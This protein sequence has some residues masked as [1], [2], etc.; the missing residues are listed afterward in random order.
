M[1]RAMLL[2]E[3]CAHAI[4]WHWLRSA[5]APA[6]VYGE[7]TFSYCRPFRSG[8]EREA[9]E[10]AE[11]IA[12]IADAFD[13]PQLES[14]REVMRGV[15]DVRPALARASMG[16]LLDDAHLLELQRWFEA[17]ERLDTL[18]AGCTDLPRVANDALAA[19][20]Q[21]LECGRTQQGFYL[22]DGFDV[23]LADAR[24]QLAR[25][26]AAYEAARGRAVAAVTTAFG[27][28]ISLPEF[29]VMRT[30]MHGP[31]PVGVRVVREAPTYLLCEL[32][33]D[34]RALDALGARDAAAIE[35]AQ[36]EEAV[37]ARLAST[38][39]SHIGALSDAAHAFG[40]VD[41]L[42]GAARFTRAYGCKVPVISDET[43][44][45]FEGARFVPL[46]AELAAA[47][48]VFTP[49]DL[50]LNG[51]AVLTGPNMGGKS[52]ALRTCGFIAACCSFGL[53]VP[54]VRAQVS[55]FDEIVWLGIGSDDDEPGG[56]LSSFAREVVRLRDVLADD[57]QPRL[58]LLDEF[59]RT[60]TP[61]EGKALFIAVI[62]RLQAERACGLAATHLSGVAEAAHVRHYAVRGLRGIPKRP[63]TDDLALALKRWRHRWTIHWRR[64][65]ASVRAKPMRSLWPHCWVSMKA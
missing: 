12:R 31:L 6:G 58:V 27:R 1:K 14:A 25:A 55:L 54:A 29:I 60:T 50:Q 11:R 7:A 33:P 10:R 64:S 57:V 24:A 61:R 47:G 23:T 43:G 32:D 2:D 30:D 5:V 41:V 9:H 21:A 22:A 18:T 46:E 63:A 13:L 44:L 59:A 34:E 8:N 62:E 35:V 65:P 42:V 26:Q 51:V 53:P 36:R 49:I 37:R 52:I 19:C 56:L 39:A 17:A 38:I 40:E 16:D 4:G 3:A 48:R 28:E 20:A 15:P 45:A